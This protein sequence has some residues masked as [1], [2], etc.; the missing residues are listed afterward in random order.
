MHKVYN[1]IESM[2]AGFL[3]RVL[4]IGRVLNLVSDLVSTGKSALTTDGADVIG[5]AI[6]FESAILDAGTLASVVFG[7]SE[8]ADLLPTFGLEASAAPS[9][10]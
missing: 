1:E 8:E 9:L 2:Y 3:F 6:L 10:M 5:S 7:L 4:R